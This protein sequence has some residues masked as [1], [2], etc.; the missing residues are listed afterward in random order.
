MTVV[1]LSV[2]V[3]GELLRRAEQLL[4]GAGEG[5]SALI[6]RVLAQAVR[7]AEEAEIDAAYDQA[8][9]RRRPRHNDLERT[10]ALAR[11]ALRSTRQGGTAG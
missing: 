2:S 5:R 10:D 8:Y 11:A 4:A 3:P 1:K 6:T 7:A 9:A